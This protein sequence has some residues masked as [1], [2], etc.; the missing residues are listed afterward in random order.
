M[1]RQWGQGTIIGQLYKYRYIDKNRIGNSEWLPS[2]GDICLAMEHAG[3]FFYH[4]VA[5]RKQENGQ[6]IRVGKF[7]GYIFGA[8]I[9]E[10][11]DERTFHLACAGE[12]VT[13]QLPNRK[14]SKKKKQS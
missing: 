1:N 4:Y 10:P 11:L 6:Y 2:N 9:G 5:L 12:P 13:L 14:A 3:D 8:E 7:G